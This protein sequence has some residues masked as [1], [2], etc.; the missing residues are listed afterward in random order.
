LGVGLGL[1]PAA[2][3]AKAYSELISTHEC[4]DDG[5]QRPFA[6]CEHVGMRSIE[7]KQRAAVLEGKP[8]SICDDTGSKAREVALD[9]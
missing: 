7:R 2:H 6:G 1:V 5:V 8:S 4:R 9:Q 3:D